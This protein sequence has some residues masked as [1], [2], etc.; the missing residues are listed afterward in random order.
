VDEG[1]RALDLDDAGRPEGE[2]RVGKVHQESGE[3]STSTYLIDR[4]DLATIVS[5]KKVSGRQSVSRTD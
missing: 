5:G 3:Q 4:R 2:G 1:D